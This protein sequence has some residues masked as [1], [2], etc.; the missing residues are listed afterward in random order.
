[1]PISKLFQK[2]TISKEQKNGVKTGLKPVFGQTFKSSQNW[3][4]A[5]PKVA[6]LHVAKSGN[7]EINQCC[8]DGECSE[9]TWNKPL[10][11]VDQLL[12]SQ[13]Y[14]QILCFGAFL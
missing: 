11:K 4:S 14:T 6:I 10:V 12:T 3:Q 1:M 5:K 8:I 2:T 7:T 9:K 13:F